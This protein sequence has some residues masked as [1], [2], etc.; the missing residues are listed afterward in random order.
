MREGPHQHKQGMATRATYKLP[1][2]AWIY[3][4]YTTHDYD[5]F[6]L[7]NNNINP[8]AADAHSLS[9]VGISK[10]KMEEMPSRRVLRANDVFYIR[11][12]DK[13]E[14]KRFAEI[15]GFYT[16]TATINGKLV[17]KKQTV[18]LFRGVPVTGQPSGRHEVR[19]AVGPKEV[20]EQFIAVQ[21]LIANSPDVRGDAS[22]W[23]AVHVLRGSVDQGNLYGMRQAYW[24]FQEEMDEWSEQA[25]AHWRKGHE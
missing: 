20:V 2:A 6:W 13:L 19:F 18:M 9:I 14:H 3:E 1:L 5:G 21:P 16:R 12:G 7:Q 4:N 22:A 10:M 17:K 23:R 8:N 25:H 11:F 15:L 24:L